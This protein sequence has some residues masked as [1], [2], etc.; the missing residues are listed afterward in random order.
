MIKVKGLDWFMANLMF[1]SIS[2][3]V[4]APLPIVHFIRWT[5]NMQDMRV[6]IVW[7]LL[8]LIFKKIVKEDKS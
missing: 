4:F 1:W 8:I 5:F 6:L 2:T 7:A 3:M